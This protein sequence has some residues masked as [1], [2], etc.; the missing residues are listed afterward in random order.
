MAFI[1]Q[2]V[3]NAFAKGHRLE[4][5]QKTEN[6]KRYNLTTPR[7][8]YGPTLCSYVPV[9]SVFGTYGTYEHKAQ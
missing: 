2:M 6:E 9:F 7:S 5:V 8:K 3:L 1:N 4:I